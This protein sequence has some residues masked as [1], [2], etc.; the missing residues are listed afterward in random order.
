M[1]GSPSLR[2]GSPPYERQ[3]T[4][5]AVGCRL[6]RFDGDQRLDLTGPARPGTTAVTATVRG[7]AAQ[8]AQD[9]QYQIADGSRH[10]ESHGEVLPGCG[11]HRWAPTREPI[12]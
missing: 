7:H 12:W 9:E 10:A 1:V 11:V 6:A 4:L 5:R 8:P 3:P 2:S